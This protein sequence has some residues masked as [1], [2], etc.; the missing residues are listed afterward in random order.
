MVYRDDWY[1][2]SIGNRSYA[3]CRKKEAMIKI[4]LLVLVLTG[5]AIKR[6]ESQVAQ[7][8]GYTKEERQP[9]LERYVGERCYA[10][11]SKVQ[12]FDLNSET[13]VNYEIT[14]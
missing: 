13:E 3:L 9:A 6:T 10:R 4:L 11:H 8:H 2:N 5:C 1:S 14:P 7:L 12:C